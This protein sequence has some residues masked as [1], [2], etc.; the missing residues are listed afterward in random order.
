MLIPRLWRELTGKTAAARPEWTQMPRVE[1]RME[2]RG[3]RARDE[4]AP[5]GTALGHEAPRRVL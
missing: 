3:R 1:N 2:V 5:E 4:W